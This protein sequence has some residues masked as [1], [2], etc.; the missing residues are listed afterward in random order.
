MSALVQSVDQYPPTPQLVPPVT[1][2][3]KAVAPACP[4]PVLRFMLSHCD[5]RCEAFPTCAFVHCHM[6]LSLL[7]ASSMLCSVEGRD[8]L[9]THIMTGI[10]FG[11]LAMG[12]WHLHTP[13]SGCKPNLDICLW[14]Q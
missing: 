4:N 2:F 6:P 10:L 7:L 11:V 13:N 1:H 9:E 5:N 14:A 12:S 3:M 8:M